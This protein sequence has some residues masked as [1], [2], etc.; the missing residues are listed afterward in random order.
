[1]DPNHVPAEPMGMVGVEFGRF[2]NF[3]FKTPRGRA[4]ILSFTGVCHQGWVGFMCPLR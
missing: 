2:F 1:M 4:E 3:N